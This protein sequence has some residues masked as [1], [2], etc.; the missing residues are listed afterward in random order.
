MHA[1]EIDRVYGCHL[2]SGPFGSNGRPIIWRGARPSSAYRVAFELARG[3]VPI[4]LVLDHLCRRERCCNPDHLEP[5]TKSENELRKSWAYRCRRARCAL[6]H[7]LD[8]AIVTPE[9]G[10]LCRTCH[11]TTR[12]TL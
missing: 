12:A 4:G 9:M 2:W 8:D 6:G 10:R 3:P 5:V 11:R 1:Y 7:A